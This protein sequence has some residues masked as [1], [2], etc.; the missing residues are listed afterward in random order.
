MDYSQSMA[1]NLSNL[2]MEGGVCLAL[3]KSG[4]DHGY[5]ISQEF[6]ADGLIGSVHT[7]SRPVVYRELAYLERD[8]MV[9]SKTTRGA[10]RQL[11]KILSLTKKG[12]EHC[13]AWLDEPVTHLR[14]M[15][16]EFLLKVLLRQRL[17]REIESFVSRQRTTLSDVIAQFSADTD[18][19]V[20]MLWR[21]EQARAVARFLD[22][23]EGRVT[24]QEDNADDGL[25]ISARN[26]LQARVIAV[27]HGGV[28]SSVKLELDPGQV[29]T[30]TITREATD[31]LRLAPG[32][33]VTALCKATDVML[34]VHR[35]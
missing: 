23:L 15:R 30:S 7:L 20:V 17:G 34:A 12:N 22:E 2:S 25:L 13:E 28:L 24:T 9:T 32:S 29:M 4:M 18:R 10:R 14:D 31:H 21:R 1:V 27:T 11:T 3:V 35:D 16:N 33:S 6:S 8:G 19:G 5:P 26:Q